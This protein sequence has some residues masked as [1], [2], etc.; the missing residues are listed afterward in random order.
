MARSEAGGDRH[1]RGPVHFVAAVAPGAVAAWAPDRE[2]ERYADGEGHQIVELY[3]RLRDRGLPVTIG[4]QPPC[5][6]LVVMSADHLVSW[7]GH[8]RRREQARTARLALAEHDH[9]HP[10]RLP[11]YAGSRVAPTPTAARADPRSTWLPLLPQRALVPRDPARRGSVRTLA[12]KAH[13]DNVPPGYRDPDVARRLGALGVELRIDDAVAAWPDFSAVDAVLCVARLQPRWDAGPSLPRKPPTKL[14]NAWAAGCVPLIA[15]QTGYLDLARPDEDAV[16]VES[17][18]AVLAQVERLVGDPAALA[19]IEAGVAAR[20]PEFARD[21]VTDRWVE[22]L[23]A[24]D[25]GRPD[26]AAAARGVVR[27]T[28]D[29]LRHRWRRPSG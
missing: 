27:A 21:V 12:I 3:A 29:A 9:P 8:P 24:P 23:W 26:R 13:A 2:P 5:G 25:R 10:G 1:A 17:P 19:R 14:V 18:A 22:H 4:P 7:F 20:R 15:P 11:D 6:A 28:A 16:V